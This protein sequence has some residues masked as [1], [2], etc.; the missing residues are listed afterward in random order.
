MRTLLRRLLGAHTT[1]D[2]LAAYVDAIGKAWD[3]GDTAAV[4]MLLAFRGLMEMR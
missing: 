2:R 4:G 1:P 3:A